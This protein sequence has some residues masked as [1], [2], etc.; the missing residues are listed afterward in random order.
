MTHVKETCDRCGPNGAE[1]SVSFGMWRVP[2]VMGITVV[3]PSMWERGNMLVR[4]LASVKHQTIGAPQVR[5]IIGRNKWE[6]RNLGLQAVDTE[7]TVF[8]DDDD[9]MLPNHVQTLA[10]AQHI[11]GIPGADL[12]WSSAVVRTEDGRERVFGFDITPEQE[13]LNNY[14]PTGYMVR[15]SLARE[16][17]GF[18]PLTPEVP[19]DWGFLQRLVRGGATFYYADP[20]EPTWIIHLHEG[21]T[22]QGEGILYT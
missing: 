8:L 2:V 6:A 20:P 1:M 11:S 22:F 5:V 7:W 10:T 18:P 19:E 4:A 13:L 3:I 12:V 17:G 15:T 16:V 21:N 14:I 9:E